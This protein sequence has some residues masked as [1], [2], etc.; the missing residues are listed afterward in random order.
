MKT[1]QKTGIR[2]R[3]VRFL[4]GLAVGL[5]LVG[6]AVGTMA[7]SAEAATWWWDGGYI[8]AKIKTS[9]AGTNVRSD[10]TFRGSVLYTIPR[11]SNMWMDF[12]CW[13]YGDGIIWGRVAGSGVFY[14]QKWVSD[15][16]INL[17]GRTL[18]S[19]GLQQCGG[20]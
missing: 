9:D 15:K 10:P 4:V 7:P 3:A 13:T 19:I 20:A 11:G 2:A 16:R 12:D 18:K 17:G 6:G 14:N 1:M 5:S 8:H